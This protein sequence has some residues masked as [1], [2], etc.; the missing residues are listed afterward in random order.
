MTIASGTIYGINQYGTSY[1]GRPSLIPDTV[2]P[3]Y[4]VDPFTAIPF[5]YQVINLSWTRPAVAVTEFRLV[6]NRYGY[7]VDETDGEVLLDSATWPGNAYVDVEIWPG[8]YHYYGIY[9]LALIGE[10]YVW[11]RAGLAA[12]LV[13]RYLA[14]ANTLYELLPETAKNIDQTELT[15]AATGDLYLFQY[16]QVLGWGLDYLKTQYQLILQANNPTVIP[17]NSLYNLAGELGF[18]F[19]PEISAGV[20]RQGV[21][22]AAHVAEER[23]TIAG[24]EN[25]ITLLTGWNAIITVGYNQLLENDQSYFPDP[26]ATYGQ[27]DATISYNTGEGVVLGNYAYTSRITPNFNHTPTTGA[28]DSNWTCVL[29]ADNT[30]ALANTVTGGINTWEARYPAASHQIA[31]AGA[32]KEGVGVS[33]PLD[34]A[35]FLHGSV[36]CYNTGGSAAAVDLRSIARTTTDISALSNDPDP[37]QVI[38]DG[39]PVQFLTPQQAWEVTSEYNTGDIVSFNAQPFIALRDSTGVAPTSNN[40][41]SNEWQ[42]LGYD[43]RMA[44]V[45]SGYASQSLSTNTNNQAVITPYVVWYDQWGRPISTVT[46]RSPYTQVTDV[47]VA[48]TA[49]LPTNTATSSTVLTASSNGAFAA[50]DGVT[51]NTIGQ[52][53]LVMNEVTTTKNGLYSLTTVGTVSTPWVLTR[54]S[55]LAAAYVGLVVSVDQGTVNAGTTWYCTNPTTPTFGSTTITFSQTAPY[56]YTPASIYFDS[57]TS[58]WGTTLN[59]RTTD[60]GG[61]QWVTEVGSM[62]VSAFSDGTVAPAVQGQRSYAVIPAQANCQV[63]VT[64]VTGPD[65]GNSQGIVFRWSSD[66]NYW[67]A[68]QGSLTKKVSG[69]YTVVA[70]HSTVFSPGDRMNITMNG[71]SITCYRNGV[72]VSTATDA[73]NDT[74]NFHGIIYEPTT[75]TNFPVQ[76]RPQMPTRRRPPKLVYSRRRIAM[77]PWPQVPGAPPDPPGNITPRRRAKPPK[78]VQRGRGSGSEGSQDYGNTFSDSY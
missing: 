17:L 77:P 35:S 5:N 78:R 76:V 15:A 21:A 51:L 60:I 23:G 3:G 18:D 11:V 52:R 56:S 24:I 72:Q 28:T 64:F 70:P 10:D 58:G 74:A 47:I 1:Y 37:E 8:S 34:P 6:R 66:G 67:R 48:T 54:V 59:A 32:I 50:V 75:I 25:K 26:I 31:G 71:S 38:R 22:N 7:P 20:V 16:M 61:A 2:P 27:W 29:D 63:G 14:S 73:F 46:G 4:I 42:P 55:T 43:S 53:I 40:I 12:C 36:R 57:F 69:V 62:S 49:A 41:P 30:T 44:L 45:F 65:T 33:D 68:D 13:A 19:E 39:I 9:L